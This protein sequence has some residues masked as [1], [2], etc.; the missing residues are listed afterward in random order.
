MQNIEKLK[1][2]EH[3]QGKA[4]ELAN[5]ALSKNT[6]KCYSTGERSVQNCMKDLNEDL[7]LPWT[8]RKAA[9]YI[10]WAAKEKK[11]AASTLEQY[12]SAIKSAH[13]RN[14]FSVDWDTFQV[15]NMMKGFKNLAEPRTQR[16]PITPAIMRKLWEALKA[17]SLPLN[18]KRL[19]WA[20]CTMLYAGSLRGGEVLGEEETCFDE[21]KTLLAKDV[22]IKELYI[23]NEKVKVL[24]LKIKN[25]KEMAGRGS[26]NVEMFESNSFTCPVR[27]VEKL[28]AAGKATKEEPFATRAKGKILTI[29]KFNKV[30]KTLLAD[31]LKYEEGTISSHSF[32]SG[33]ATAMARAGY[34]DAEIQRVGRWRSDA[35]LKYLKL[36]R[37]SRLEQQRKL[38]ACLEEIGQKEIQEMNINA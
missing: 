3:L 12:L 21:H 29:S 10:T 24:M 4:L 1:L 35:F 8:E 32:R 2:P 15:K 20:V 25:P 5:A 38:M 18:E 33:V 7:S 19:I 30:L 36:G 26:L 22:N 27:A 14:G 9:I 13:R 34:Q 28:W 16:L 6:W 31:T 37:S 23:G 17:A 11:W